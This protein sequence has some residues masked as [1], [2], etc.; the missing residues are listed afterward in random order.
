MHKKRN[1]LHLSMIMKFARIVSVV[2]LLVSVRCFFAMI[3]KLYPDIFDL[4]ISL[5]ISAKSPSCSVSR[6]LHA[7]NLA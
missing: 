6:S 4:L 5:Y 2:G 1:P 3:A 7:L